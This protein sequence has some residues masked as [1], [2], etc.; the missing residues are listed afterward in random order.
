M[1]TR[2]GW[3]FFFCAIP[4]DSWP[5]CTKRGRSAFL[6]EARA[7]TGDYPVAEKDSSD[8]DWGK[9]TDPREFAPAGRDAASG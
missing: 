1:L 7:P 2:G 4:L 5:V 9:D 6:R 3:N 8:V